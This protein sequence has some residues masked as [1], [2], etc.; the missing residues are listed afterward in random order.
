[1]GEVFSLLITK[2]SWVCIYLEVD[3]F[4]LQNVQLKYDLVQDD[5]KKEEN[6]LGVDRYVKTVL[7]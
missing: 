5:R 4:V 6:R 7:I 3:F 1:M 2:S